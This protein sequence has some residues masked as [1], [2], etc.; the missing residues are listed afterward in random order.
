MYV[1]LIEI[2]GTYGYCNGTLLFY[3]DKYQHQVQL[4]LSRVVR[5]VFGLTRPFVSVVMRFISWSRTRFFAVTSRC[6]L[7][8]YMATVAPVVVARPILSPIIPVVTTIIDHFPISP[9]VTSAIQ[10]EPIA[11][12]SGT[13][14]PIA[15]ISRSVPPVTGIPIRLM[16]V[17]TSGLSSVSVARVISVVY[18][19]LLIIVCWK[20][21][22]V[23]CRC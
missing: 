5:I 23:A 22:V 21:R 18:H 20:V 19:F 8:I 12:L 10:K 15:I 16:A 3:S 7:M 4:L 1:F 9:V 14:S 13:I 2:K 17:E 6:V 11:V